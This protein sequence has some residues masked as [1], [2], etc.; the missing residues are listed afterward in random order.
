MRD[1]RRE[2]LSDK[3]M[4]WRIAGTGWVVLLL[5]FILSIFEWHLMVGWKAIIFC[6]I[7]LVFSGIFTCLAVRAKEEEKHPPDT[8]DGN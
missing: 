3:R 7:S 2:K 6:G 8:S 4:Y 5:C 1:K